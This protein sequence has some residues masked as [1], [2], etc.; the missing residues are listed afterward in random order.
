M[1]RTARRFVPFLGRPLDLH[2]QVV[3]HADDRDGGCGDLPLLDA[4]EIRAVGICDRHAVRLDVHGV[5]APVGL[6]LY[7][8]WYGHGA[9]VDALIHFAVD[10][11][12][13]RLPRLPV[14][15]QQQKCAAAQNASAANKRTQNFVCFIIR[16][17]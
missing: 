14:A 2:R 1:A 3:R 7:I 12:D 4:Q 16:S 6:H 15:A 17:F 8:I 9:Q 11:D 5:H 10:P 13:G